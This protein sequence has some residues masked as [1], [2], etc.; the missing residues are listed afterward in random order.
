MLSLKKT[1]IWRLLFAVGLLAALLVPADG[2]SAEPH[3]AGTT[4][5]TTCAVTAGVAISQHPDN[6]SGGLDSNPSDG[7][8]EFRLPR[9]DCQ[10]LLLDGM[11]DHF[12]AAIEVDTTDI[13]HTGAGED[14]EQGG[15]A[16][17]GDELH[18][19][20]ITLVGDHW[21]FDGGV[22]F[23]RLGTTVLADGPL[24]VTHSHVEPPG[25][26]HFFQAELEFVPTD[27]NCVDD[28]LTQARV[29]G[30]AQIYD[31][32]DLGYFHDCSL[33]GDSSDPHCEIGGGD[34]FDGGSDSE[35]RQCQDAGGDRV[36]DSTAA[37]V[38]TFVYVHQ[39]TTD[40][41]WVCARVEETATG[42]GY[43]GRLEATPADA[44]PQVTGVPGIPSTDSDSTAC[45]TTTPN[46][47]PGSHPIAYG[48]VGSVD[49]MV[50]AYADDSE[51]WVCLQVGS[52][53]HRVVVPL[54]SGSPDVQFGTVAS[55]HP[56]EGA[57]GS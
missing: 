32:T 23:T 25:G 51:A 10:A 22:H 33:E 11:S 15:N 9:L 12:E 4:P 19:G 40:E 14:C 28:P 27:G 38:R 45:T 56:D 20:W 37:G 57:P 3:E 35:S 16:K 5:H 55:W 34:L 42:E 53:D 24:T 21:E 2:A 26:E 41:V 30:W 46:D 47:V 52:S 13:S 6:W 43:G 29:D 54:G 17:V 8:Y 1:M 7:N 36:I 48:G 39:P 18:A 49:Y 44:D 50:D 31:V